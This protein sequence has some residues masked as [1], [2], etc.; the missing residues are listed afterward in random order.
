M[1]HWSLAGSKSAANVAYNKP[2]GQISIM[3]GADS[4][5][6]VD[7]VREPDTSRSEEGCTATGGYNKTDNWWWVNLQDLYAIRNVVIYNRQG[8]CKAYT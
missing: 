2:T 5:R 4:G 8:S 7:G 1:L 3:N 6:A